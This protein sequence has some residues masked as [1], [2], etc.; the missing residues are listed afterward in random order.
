M[1]QTL[2]VKS[3]D[4]SRQFARFTSEAIS[5]GVIE[6]EN[7]NRLVGAFLSPT[8]YENYQRLKMRERQVSL[9]SELPEDYKAMLL[10]IKYGE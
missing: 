1:S 10:D 5:K 2:A 4:F 3:T 9:V 6:V 7:H 8:E